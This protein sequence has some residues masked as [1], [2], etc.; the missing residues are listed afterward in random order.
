MAPRAF[1]EIAA[2]ADRV[3]A[4]DR[5]RVGTTLTAMG[6]M[7]YHAMVPGR[8]EANL[9]MNFVKET[10]GGQSLCAACGELG[11]IGAKVSALSHENCGHGKKIALVGLSA[12]ENLSL[13]GWER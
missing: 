1:E 5:L 13:P 10:L 11:N 4:L 2:S 8:T 9:G 3:S 6:V 12:L 7:G